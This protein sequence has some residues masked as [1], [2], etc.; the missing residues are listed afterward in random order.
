MER[1][2]S[3]PREEAT[4]R[5]PGNCIFAGK[6]GLGDPA[7]RLPATRTQRRR[8]SSGQATSSRRSH[9]RHLRVSIA[10]VNSSGC[11]R[12]G[13]EISLG[14]GSGARLAP[15]LSQRSPQGSSPATGKPRPRQGRGGLR[16]LQVWAHTP[17]LRYR[18]SLSRSRFASGLRRGEGEGSQASPTL[19]PGTAPLRKSA[20]SLVT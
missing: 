16:S 5:N 17:L 11:H 1:T 9:L 10:N 4:R 14:G 3:H 7:C 20:V 13:A 15:P 12:R 6:P 8:S 18:G 19:S 2:S